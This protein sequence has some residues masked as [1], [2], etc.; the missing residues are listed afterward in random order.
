MKSF[1]KALFLFSIISLAVSCSSQWHLKK[2][3]KKDP[4]ILLVDT[5][6]FTD[7]DTFI[8]ESIR[9]DTSFFVSNDTTIIV[10]DRLTVKHFIHNDTVH[11]EAE[12]EG[13]T[14]IQ[15]EIIEVP[16]DRWIAPEK[17]WFE[18]LPPVWVWLLI[19]GLIIWN[20]YFRKN[21]V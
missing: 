6:R 17:R 4:S 21:Q 13:D 19:A 10:K 3:I 9:H 5:V 14:I 2:A 8:T 16:V 1:I 7:I 11:I 18:Y 20:K 15:T 12:C